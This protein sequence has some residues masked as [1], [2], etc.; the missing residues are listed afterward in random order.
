MDV[1]KQYKQ[2]ALY[3]PVPAIAPDSM[4]SNGFGGE[5][6]AHTGTAVVTTTR[7]TFKI[8]APSWGPGRVNFRA[9]DEGFGLERTPKPEIQRGPSP[10]K[11]NLICGPPLYGFVSIGES[12]DKQSPRADNT[13][14]WVWCKLFLPVHVGHHGLG[15]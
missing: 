8:E 1:T 11:G 13:A 7:S 2:H 6:F 5:Y 3:G 9:P 4:N 12:I 10:Q 14:N 15:T